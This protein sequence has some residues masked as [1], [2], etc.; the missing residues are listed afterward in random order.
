MANEV[1]A[2]STP[3]G[4]RAQLAAG[5]LPAAATGM[6]QPNPFNPMLPS[7][8]PFS[9]QQPPQEIVLPSPGSAEAL[10][11]DMVPVDRLILNEGPIA[12]TRRNLHT[13]FVTLPKALV[14]GLRGSEDYTFSDFMLLGRVPYYL[15]G[16]VLTSLFVAASPAP[17]P[18]KLNALKQ[19]LGALFYYT[20]VKTANGL[21]NSLYKW[22]Y[23]VDL[24]QKYKSANGRIE[25]VFASHDFVRIDLL[26][27]DQYETMRQKMDIPSDIN[28]PKGAVQEQLRRIVSASRATK[29][30][31][32]NLLAVIGAG[33]LARTDAWAHLLGVPDALKRVFADFKQT[34]S[35]R[36]LVAR[37]GAILKEALASPLG[38]KLGPRGGHPMSKLLALSGLALGLS[39]AV[40]HNAFFVVE[41]K[42]YVRS[43]YA[44][45]PLA[46]AKP[47][48]GGS[49]A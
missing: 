37:T 35:I 32:G 5:Q 31:V 29:L 42:D 39:W 7:T 41:R 23:G 9:L 8:S 18:G 15:G 4:W 20:G 1:T 40:I 49:V 27:D 43:R 47:P 10:E 14:A 24:G 16:L 6:P 12:A 38:E 11:L 46:E 44:S 21:V 19:G 26:N 33:Y 17:A 28:D 25:E 13:A 22:R 45:Q 36:N 48:A 3:A 30:I 2:I 34:G